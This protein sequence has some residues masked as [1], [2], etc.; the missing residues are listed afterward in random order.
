V[1]KYDFID[2]DLGKAIPYGIYDIDKNDCFVNVCKSYDSFSFAVS[3]IRR[4]WIAMGQPAYSG[5]KRLLITADGGGSNGY[6]RKQ[7]KTELQQLSDEF[8]L[9]ITVLHFPP[10]TSKWN[11]IEHRL[12]F[13]NFHELERLALD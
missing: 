3:S 2:G 11:K 7:W 1:G 8:Q 13:L 10:G 5:K 4:W 12:F 6:R 9:E